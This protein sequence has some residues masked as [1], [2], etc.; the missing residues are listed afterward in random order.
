MRL[1]QF[2]DPLE[3]AI[4]DRFC[5]RLPACPLCLRHQLFIPNLRFHRIQRPDPC[6]RLLRLRRLDIFR[7]EDLAARMRPACVRLSLGKENDVKF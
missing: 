4:D 3:E 1:E 7:L 5:L 6:Q 2:V